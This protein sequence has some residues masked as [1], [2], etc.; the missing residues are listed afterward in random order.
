MALTETCRFW[1]LEYYPLLHLVLSEAFD[2]LGT[3]LTRCSN[4]C[5]PR[6]LKGTSSTSLWVLLLNLMGR[7]HDSIKGEDKER[8]QTEFNMQIKKTMDK[9][10]LKAKLFVV[11]FI[12]NSAQFACSSTNCCI[13]ERVW[14][15]QQ[16]WEW[17][18]EL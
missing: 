8:A 4:K 2:N 5:M 14:T 11:N 9:L 3:E 7:T 13:M 17:F 12:Y 1:A 16:M 6:L 10:L 18:E 15:S